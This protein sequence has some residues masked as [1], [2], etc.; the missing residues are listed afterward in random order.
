MA[1][2]ELDRPLAASE[3]Q[4]AQVHRLRKGKDLRGLEVAS[5]PS[6]PKAIP[7]V[8]LSPFGRSCQLGRASAA[9]D[10]AARAHR[11]RAEGRNR[12][13][14]VEGVDAAYLSHM[15]S[16]NSAANISA[17]NASTDTTAQVWSRPSKT[18]LPA[19][20]KKPKVQL[21]VGEA[22]RILTADAILAHVGERYRRTG[23]ADGRHAALNTGSG[24]YKRKAG[25]KALPFL[26]P[27]DAGASS[28]GCADRRGRVLAI[29]L[30]PRTDEEAGACGAGRLVTGEN[31]P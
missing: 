2:R 16:N 27:R 30:L 7:A 5:E 14:V 18:K 6:R 19:R 29:L 22:D 13:R 28:R 17:S 23:V 1:P 9:D 20:Q 21:I 8:R 12:R 25:A 11:A 10:A 4:C 31:S 24:A 15:P 26:I 3:G